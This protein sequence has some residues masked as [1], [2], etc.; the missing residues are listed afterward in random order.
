MTPPNTI[1][2]H[3][4][5][6]AALV[7]G[8][9]LAG[10]L[11]SAS[12]V[13]AGRGAL[14]AEL[15]LNANSV[16]EV[17]VDPAGA[18][19]LRARELRRSGPRATGSFVATNQTSAR[20]SVRLRSRP[21]SRELDRA[22]AVRVTAGGR[23]LFQGPMGALRRWSPR[24]ASLPVQGRVRIRFEVA[25]PRSARNWQNRMAESTIELRAEPK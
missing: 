2:R 5:R 10:A 3:S 7:A 11:V 1:L 13:P 21:E 18:P 20:L 22:L 4:V 6:L 9:A 25:V 14:G 17:A 12:G 19:F 15:L 23:V 24:A 16:G 8:L